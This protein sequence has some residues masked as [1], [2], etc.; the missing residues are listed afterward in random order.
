MSSRKPR[1]ELKMQEQAQGPV[2]NRETIE[3]TA[4]GLT[5]LSLTASNY[6]HG[7]LAVQ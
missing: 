6:G 3:F 1:K 4:L 2:Q 5:S 7:S